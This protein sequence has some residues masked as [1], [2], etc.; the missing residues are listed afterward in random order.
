[1]FYQNFQRSQVVKNIEEEMS[2]L[3]AEIQNLGRFSKNMKNEKLKQLSVD[4][5]MMP[6]ITR[7]NDELKRQIAELNDKIYSVRKTKL[8]QVFETLAAEI[9]RAS[10]RERV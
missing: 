5:Q 2:R 8:I 3:Q 1:M 4:M 6:E 7:E 10:C 9:G